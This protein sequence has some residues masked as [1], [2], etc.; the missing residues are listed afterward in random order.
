MRTRLYYVDILSCVES[1]ALIICGE[2]IFEV[3]SIVRSTFRMEFYNVCDLSLI[4]Y[5]IY[6]L[7]PVALRS[8]LF[9]T[10]DAH[11]CAAMPTIGG[12]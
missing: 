9:L 6:L 2:V 3:Q 1:Q 11:R 12:V 4:I 7:G 8:A 10:H 5:P